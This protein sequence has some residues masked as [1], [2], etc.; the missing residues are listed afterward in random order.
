MHRREGR[1]LHQRR[2]PQVSVQEDQNVDESCRDTTAFRVF[3][4]QRSTAASSPD[5]K[6]RT[7]QEY[8][9]TRVQRIKAFPPLF[10][11]FSFLFWTL[12][13]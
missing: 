9:N 3:I 12:E 6:P 2:V 4:V 5:K 11:Q 8:V 7:D 13:R 1:F 10:L